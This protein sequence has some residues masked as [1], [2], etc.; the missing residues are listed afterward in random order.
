VSASSSR[1]PDEKGVLVV[2]E[3]T[4]IQ[5]VG[6]L[7]NCRRLEV[8]GYIEG[9]MTA[10]AVRVHRNGRCYGT[11]KTD[12]AEVHGELQ[13]TL[14]VKNLIDI[15]SSG[16]VS[17][18]VHYGKLALEAGGHLSAEVR[19]VP[20]TLAGDLSLKVA[21]GRSMPI[22]PQHLSAIDPDDDARDLIFAVSNVRHGR[23]A[24]A[25][26]PE[27]AITRFTQADLVAGKVVFA[28]DASDAKAASFDV[29]VTDHAGA[30]SGVPQTVKVTVAAP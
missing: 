28:H 27:Q 3:G 12:A 13:G 23:V 20:P 30:T 8:H 11:V 4:I 21:R 26:R 14:F 22:T 25:A 15:R 2:T 1:A 7:H 29:V 18:N 6:E 19:N 9:E 17:G 16:S 10:G 5:G 24:L